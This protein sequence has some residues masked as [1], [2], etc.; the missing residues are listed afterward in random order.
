M[1]G[2]RRDDRHGAAGNHHQVR[3]QHGAGFTNPNRA[4]TD[5]F[6]GALDEGDLVFPHQGLDPLH[7]LPDRLVLDGHHGFH[8]GFKALKVN[9]EMAERL[10]L[11]EQMRLVQQALGRNAAH[12]QTGATQRPT[13]HHRHGETV[14]GGPDG[15]G[16]ATHAAA[17]HQQL[18]FFVQGAHRGSRHW[19]SMTV[20]PR[21]FAQT[22][23]ISTVRH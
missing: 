12:V 10:G 8:G 1:A 7:Q 18:P 19:P 23:E 17:N 20:S 9:T 2:N 4:G 16:V 3:V 13:F 15:C 11:A 22:K 21:W 5:K 14:F 6:S